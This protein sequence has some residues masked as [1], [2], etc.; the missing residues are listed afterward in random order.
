MFQTELESVVALVTVLFGDQRWQQF[1]GALLGFVLDLHLLWDIF[2]SEN[3][4]V[5]DDPLNDQTS[6]TKRQ[7]H[8][9]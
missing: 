1:D 3:A 4:A 2:A 9:A 5:D 6:A 8:A 7:N